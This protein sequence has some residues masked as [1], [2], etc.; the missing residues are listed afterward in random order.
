MARTR[1]F[2]V[3]RRSYRL[4]RSAAARGEPLGEHTERARE[5][6]LSRRAMLRSTAASGLALSLPSLGAG[7]GG[8]E[9]AA[10][11]VAIVGAGLAGM[12][13]AHRL[14]QMGVSVEVFEAWNRTGG[15]TFTARGM[16]D[17]DQLCEL[18]GELIDTGH[19]VMQGLAMELG[20][21]LDDLF[22][23]DLAD[24]WWFGGRAVPTAE[25]V[26]AFEPVA[27]AITT[28]LE[29]TFDLEVRTARAGTT[30]SSSRSTCSSTRG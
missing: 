11:P 17:G 30:T 22:E 18:G 20:L 4:R 23:P 25:I 27:Q 15:R 13:C 14:S 12:V 1:L 5:A 28:Q 10:V 29:A 24:T 16:L 3:I 6:Y 8:G 9:T 19:E 26:T 2:D 21:D 7:C